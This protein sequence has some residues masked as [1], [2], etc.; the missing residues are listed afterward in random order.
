MGAT[1]EKVRVDPSKFKVIDGKLYLF[2]Y[3]FINNTLNKWNADEKKL[4]IAADK[5][6]NLILLKK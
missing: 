5:N 4:K 3:S 2:Y 1:S 6:W